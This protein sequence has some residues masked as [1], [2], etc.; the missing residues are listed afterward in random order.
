MQL[1]TGDYLNFVWLPDDMSDSQ[2]E[3]LENF[4]RRVDSI[5][6][7]NSEYFDDNPISFVVY[8]NDSTYETNN[9]LDEVLN[10]ITSKKRR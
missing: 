2:V 3:M 1:C 9:S 6:D 5:V 7:S 8:T 4:A 10:D